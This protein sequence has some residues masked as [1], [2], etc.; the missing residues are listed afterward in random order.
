MMPGQQGPRQDVTIQ[1]QLRDDR[2]E[3]AGRSHLII[4]ADDLLLSLVD[5]LSNGGALEEPPA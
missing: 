2:F 4:P 1:G 3:D 5:A